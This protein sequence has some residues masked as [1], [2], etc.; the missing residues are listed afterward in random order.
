MDKINEFINHKLPENFLY[1][2]DLVMEKLQRCIDKLLR[3]RLENGQSI[4]DLQP[5][6]NEL[7][8]QPFGDLK[9]LNKQ[10]LINAIQK[11]HVEK[12]MLEK[13]RDEQLEILAKDRLDAEKKL[14]EERRRMRKRPEL[15]NNQQIEHD[16]NNN[17]MPSPDLS[18]SDYEYDVKNVDTSDDD[19]RYDNK[20][21]DKESMIS[22]LTRDSTPYRSYND[23]YRNNI[24]ASNT[25]KNSP[26]HSSS[27]SSTPARFNSNQTNYNHCFNNSKNTPPSQNSDYENLPQNYKATIEIVGPASSSPRAVHS[28]KPY[29]IPVTA[30]I[31]SN[32]PFDNN[33]LNNDGSINRNAAPLNHVA[34]IKASPSYYT[35][36]YHMPDLSLSSSAHGHRIVNIK[37]AEYIRSPN[38]IYTRTSVLNNNNHTSNP[39]IPQSTSSVLI[40]SSGIYTRVQRGSSSNNST[41]ST[42]NS[43]N[44][45]TASPLSFVNKLRAGSLRS[46]QKQTQQ[47]LQQFELLNNKINNS[48]YV[49][50]STKQMLQNHSFRIANIQQQQSSRVFNSVE[51]RFGSMNMNLN[52]SSHNNNQHHNHQHQHVQN[53]INNNSL[54]MHKNKTS[55]NGNSPNTSRHKQ[56]RINNNKDLIEQYDFI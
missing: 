45:N 12:S 34:S 5:P 38:G 32:P 39:Q 17:S 26:S 53:E 41:D 13:N 1:D 7:P 23:I 24:Q 51:Q 10:D 4:L 27:V 16:S 9:N 50:P 30:S 36:S 11:Y 47:S 42:E 3:F 55:S 56:S 28:S 6:N 15:T 29:V 14:R 25:S 52:R 19:E 18:D 35:N 43:N 33:N 2:D 8:T 40:S 49:M 46:I 22:N 54:N 20:S 31:M 37:N 21:V 44:S 48:A